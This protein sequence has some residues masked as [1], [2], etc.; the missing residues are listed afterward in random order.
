MSSLRTI[1]LYPVFH[2]AR[3]GLFWTPIFY[4][5]LED[6]VGAKDALLL[7]AAYFA[8]VVLFEVPS[9]YLADRVGRRATLMA[10]QVAGALGGALFYLASDVEHPLALL[11]VAQVFFAMWHAC[12]SGT[13]AALLYDALQEHGRESEFP[14]REAQGQFLLA[15]VARRCVLGR[16]RGLRARRLA[17]LPP[18]GGLMRCC[19]RGLALYERTRARIRQ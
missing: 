19:V 1:A 6:Q 14:R 11:L 18:Y 15:P 5:F 17:A 7:E 16:W 2:I 4:F 10:S 3:A 12:F 8:L 13:T 9:G